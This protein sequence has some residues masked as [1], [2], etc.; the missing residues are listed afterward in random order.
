[1]PICFTK[2]YFCFAHLQKFEYSGSITDSI[3]TSGRLLRNTTQ[4][5]QILQTEQLYEAIT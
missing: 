1:M 2:N 4:L 5:T 3:L